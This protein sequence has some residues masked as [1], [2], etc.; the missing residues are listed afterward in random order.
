[1]PLIKCKIRFK[2]NWIEHCILSSAWDSAKLTDA[3]LHVLLVTLSTKDN[4]SLTN[5]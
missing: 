2:L 1:M 4:V 5:N 3:K